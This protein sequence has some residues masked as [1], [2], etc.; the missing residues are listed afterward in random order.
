MLLVI[1]KTE[2]I[3]LK[4]DQRPS[5]EGLGVKFMFVVNHK[6]MQKVM[7]KLT[8]REMTA[9]CMIVTNH[10]IYMQSTYMTKLDKLYDK[11]CYCI[12]SR[13]GPGSG[14]MVRKLKSTSPP[15]FTSPLVSPH[16]TL[17][18]QL[19]FGSFETVLV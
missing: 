5:T 15:P 16:G 8:Y 12:I 19:T 6:N 14:A 18:F 2:E 11:P 17:T 1:S 4:T 13:R 3:E 7:P 10:H 9:A